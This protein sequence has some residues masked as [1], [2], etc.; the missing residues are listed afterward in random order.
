MKIICLLKRNSALSR[1]EFI[2]HYEN[3]HVKLVSNLLPF[4]S[5]YKR[6]YINVEDAYRT[7]H[8]DNQASSEPPFDVVTELSFASRAMY[9]Q[10]V[11]ALADP[12]IGKAIADDE[13][14]VFDRSA[15]AVYMVDEYLGA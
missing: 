6:N 1:D 14:H 15:M 12:V 2:D 13:D 7:D 10:M 3:R 8:L 5:E 11:A 9:E 4:F